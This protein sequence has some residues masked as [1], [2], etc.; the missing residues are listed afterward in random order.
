MLALAFGP[1]QANL[2]SWWVTSGRAGIV[3]QFALT[4]VGVASAL[5]RAIRIQHAVRRKSASMR[6]RGDV[7][8]VSFCAACPLLGH[9]QAIPTLKGGGQL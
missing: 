5:S 1:D 2:R 7:A 8:L 6:S 9:F 4:G 3:A